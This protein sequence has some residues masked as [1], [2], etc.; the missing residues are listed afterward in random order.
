MRILFDQAVYDMRN[1]GNI[2]LLQMALRRIHK[3]WPEASL[4]VI[5]DAPHLL[6]LYCPEAFPV[7]VFSDPNW[8]DNREKFERFH[9]IIPSIAVRSLFE[10]REELQYRGL[11][12]NDIR[13]HLKSLRAGSGTPQNDNQPEIISP[14]DLY[15]SPDLEQALQGADMFIATGGG[16]MVDTDMIAG[17][18][19]LQR[20]DRAKNMGKFTALV[21]QGFGPIENQKFRDLAAKVLPE[22]DLILVRE[23]LFAIP[24]LEA[25]GVCRDRVYMSGDDAVELAYEARKP[26]LDDGIGVSVR[27][28]QYTNVAQ[29]DLVAIRSVLHNFA[30]KYKSKLIGIPTSC[31]GT[32]ADQFKI[33]QLLYGYSKASLSYLRFESISD[34]L[35]RVGQCRL[36]IAGTFHGAIFALSQG[37][38]CICLAKT[39]EYSIKFQGLVDQFGAGCQV[40]YLADKQLLDT[41]EHILDRFWESADALRPLLLESARKQIELG[42]LGYRRLYD[43]YENQYN[44]TH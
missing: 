19:V 38:P 9:R 28:A 21:G 10:L 37:I 13:T 32:E 36:V 39:E 30:A 18:H 16:Y 15:Y 27:L 34:L 42:Q 7:N 26:Q 14:P 4:E 2:A 22:V 6:R 33:E 41:F 11:T 29:D 1:K 20:L 40:L 44:L 5:T 23:G 17:Y 35:D 43:M 25:L 3:L 24:I 8:S 31:C 12:P